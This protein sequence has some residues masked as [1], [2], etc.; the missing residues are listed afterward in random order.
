VQGS[1]GVV[2]EVI[3]ND[4]SS[5]SCSTEISCDG[6]DVALDTTPIEV[7][8]HRRLRSKQSYSAKV[9]AEVKVRFG[10]PKRTDANVKAIQRFAAEI[11]RKHGVRVT[12]VRKVLPVIIEAAF[13]V[14][15]WELDARRATL[16]PFAMYRKAEVKFLEWLESKT[17]A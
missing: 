16:G 17:Q 8:C 14:D 10:T 9:L 3:E 15:K 5:S 6:V 2:R 12:E 11:M 4:G 1:A 7:K 13:V